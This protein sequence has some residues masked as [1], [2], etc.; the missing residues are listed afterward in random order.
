MDHLSQFLSRP[1]ESGRLSLTK[2]RPR[3]KKIPFTRFFLADSTLYLYSIPLVQGSAQIWS[4]RDGQQTRH[5]MRR[6]CR[7]HDHGGRCE[8]ALWR[9]WLQ[10]SAHALVADG[11]L[12]LVNLGRREARPAQRDE[13]EPAACGP[14]LMSGR[15]APPANPQSYSFSILLLLLHILTPRITIWRVGSVVAS[16]S[17][18]T[19]HHFWMKCGL[20]NW[21]RVRPAPHPCAGCNGG[22]LLVHSG[23]CYQR[24]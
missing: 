5:S 8:Q 10:S 24:A 22:R 21:A 16:A 20:P 4:Y 17:S 14:T 6:A 2:P 18:R 12:R 1:R 3:P 13:D 15:P 9:G 19:A 7:S 11:N 23:R